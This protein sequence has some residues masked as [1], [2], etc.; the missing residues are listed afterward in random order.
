MK[1]YFSKKNLL[2]AGG[3][4]LLALLANNARAAEV[5]GHM[6][7][8]SD[9][10][11]RGM[12]LSQGPSVNANLDLN[13]D[14]GLYGGAW[15]GQV[16]LDGSEASERLDWYAGFNKSF[17][18]V[19]VDVS[20]IDYGFRGDSDLDFEEVKVGLGLFDDKV[21]LYHHVGMDDMLDY[22]EVQMNMFKVADFSL[23]YVDELG[24]NWKISKGFDLL[25][26]KLEVGYSE[27]NADDDALVEDEDSF[28]IGY[29][30][31]LF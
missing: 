23:G 8:N 9:Y 28:F 21:K 22:S 12:N 5:S 24:T 3:I 19:S 26:G 13:L 18:G 20:Y 2:I 10:I 25:G 17:G 6:G 1:K 29:S 27:F 14:N 4:L 31:K 11:W 15:I 30:R 16:E 7:V